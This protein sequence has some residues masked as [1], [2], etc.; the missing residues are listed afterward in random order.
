M[1]HLVRHRDQSPP[2]RL[3][4]VVGGLEPQ[5]LA[6]L[7]DGEALERQT[8]ITINRAVILKI[9]EYADDDT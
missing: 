3:A 2:E 4:D 9:I 7:H 5:L 6:G 1:L 8:D